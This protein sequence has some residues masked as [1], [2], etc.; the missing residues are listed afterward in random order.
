M[1]VVIVIISL[2]LLI[3]LHEFGHFY[4][5][6]KFDV[7]VEE[8]GIGIPPRLFGKKIGETLYSVNL[9]PL[10]GFVRMV[11]EDEKVKDPRSFSEKPIWQ[12]AIILVAGVVSFWL[13]AIFIFALVAFGWGV[14]T[15]VPDDFATD[16]ANLYV[17]YVDQ[18]SQLAEKI[19]PQ[20]R[21]VAVNDQKIDT[22][23]GF[24]NITQNENVETITMQRKDSEKKIVISNQQ[25]AELS[26]LLGVIRIIPQKKNL[27]GALGFGVQRTV[28][29]T[30]MQAAGMGMLLKSAVTGAEL[31]EGLE[32]GGPLMIGDMAIDAL[33]R[34][35]GDYLMFVG[36]IATV[37]AFMNI[38]PIPALDGGRILFLLIEKLRGRPISAQVEQKVNAAF[39][40][41]LIMLMIV[42]TVRDIYTIF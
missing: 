4:F 35:L 14:L 42:I 18:D 11:G 23:A 39:F 36:I 21:I 15:Q 41:L 31:P 9:L 40:L 30:K 37:L 16:D 25:A 28:D 7:K 8:F 29:I 34:N 20:D 2:V 5:A 22:V 3:T 17:V 12:R 33:N 27:F 38:L 1:N 13:I 10:G 19:A 32:F 26:N 24:E 6:K